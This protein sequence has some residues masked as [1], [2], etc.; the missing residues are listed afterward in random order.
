M[1]IEYLLNKYSSLPLCLNSKEILI[2]IYFIYF[3]LGMVNFSNGYDFYN[4]YRIFEV[5]SLLIFDLW[6]IHNRQFTVTKIELLFFAFIGIGGFFWPQPLFMVTD[7]L[8]AYLLVKGFQFLNYN[9]LIAKMMVL[10]SLALFLMLPVALFDYVNSG[11]YIPNWYPLSWNIRVYD[12]YFLILSIFATWFYISEERYKN[13]YLLFLFLAFFAVLLDG[14]RSVTLAYT[15]FITFVVVCHKP[16]RLPLISIY[17]CSWLAYV[18]ITYAASF[19]SQELGIARE[20]SSGRIEL[21]IDGLTCWLQHPIMGCGFYQLKQYPSPYAHPHNIFIQVL[22]E[23]GLIGLSF[24]LFTVFRI[25]K[26]ISWNFKK[27][28]FVIA[29]LLAVVIDTSLSGIH[30]YPVTQMALLWLFVFLL[31]N[32]AF[33]HAKYFN[34]E[35]PSVSHSQQLFSLLIYILI[36]AWFVYLGIQAFGFPEDM[37]MTPPRFWVYGY[38]LY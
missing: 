13:I 26:H 19:G 14:G 3:I 2:A 17:V 21:W 6:S 5:T 11:T 36:A 4:E 10:S 31:K 27:N 7:L 35:P 28:F 32:P 1:S 34:Q 29:A 18:A 23:T 22:T 9:E 12:S 15:V 20:S 25:V 37:S 8:L 33:E 30:V 24:L 38:K 16:T